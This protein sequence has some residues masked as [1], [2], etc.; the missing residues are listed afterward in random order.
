MTHMINTRKLFFLWV[1]LQSEELGAC[2]NHT[3]PSFCPLYR[4]LSLSLSFNIHIY[5]YMYMW[6]ELCFYYFKL[7]CAKMLNDEYT[8]YYMYYDVVIY[9]SDLSVETD[10][11]SFQMINIKQ[12][13]WLLQKTTTLVIQY[14]IIKPNNIYNTSI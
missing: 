2:A 3:T 14:H 8:R 10:V 12:W 9:L 13:Q 6:H 7:A 11:L 1:I 5:I 4:A